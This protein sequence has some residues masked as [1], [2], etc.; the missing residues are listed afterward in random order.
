MK[1][2]ASSSTDVSWIVNMMNQRGIKYEVTMNVENGYQFDL[3]PGTL[4]QE[5]MSLA[6]SIGPFDYNILT[7]T[8]EIDQ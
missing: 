7:N 2:V 5:L 1:I 6:S 3:E 4:W 8:I